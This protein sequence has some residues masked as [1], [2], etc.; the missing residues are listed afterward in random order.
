MIC[1]SFFYLVTATFV[2]QMG[3]D[4]LFTRYMEKVAS[5]EGV[6]A[7]L[8]IMDLNNISNS[9]ASYAKANYT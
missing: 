4:A 5:R 7:F 1:M 8:D 6:R 3:N 9:L 2:Q